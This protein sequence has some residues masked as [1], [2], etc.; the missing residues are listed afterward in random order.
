MIWINLILFVLLVNFYGG[1]IVANYFFDD[2][3]IDIGGYSRS[4][5]DVIFR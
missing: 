5:D 4:F 2:I 3:L 1:F